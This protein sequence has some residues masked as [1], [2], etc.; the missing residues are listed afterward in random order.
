[1]RRNIFI[2]IT[3]T[4]LLSACA[5]GKGESA[6]LFVDDQTPELQVTVQTA[7]PTPADAVVLQALTLLGVGYRNAGKIPQ[8]GFDCSGLVRY[9]YHEARGID[10]P[11]TAAELARVGKNVERDALRPGDLVFYNTLRRAYSHVGIYLGE[12]RFIHAPR[13]GSEVRI[14][15]MSSHYWVAR[16]D[17]ARRILA[18][19]SQ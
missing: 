19:S 16:F 10:L 4:C 8:T 5:A 2:I 1:M 15:D 17:G 9:V 18:A 6:R 11:N 14:E 12:N 13:P 7:P 3:L